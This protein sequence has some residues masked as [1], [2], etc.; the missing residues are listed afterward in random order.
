LNVCGDDHLDVQAVV[1]RARK[2]RQ[3]SEGASAL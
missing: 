1:A 3:N 2:E